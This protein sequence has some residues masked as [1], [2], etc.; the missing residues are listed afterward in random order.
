MQPFDALTIRAVLD[1]AK[2]LLLNRRVDRVF[3]LGR[4]ELLISLR[5]KSGMVH[6]LL[7]AHATY[8]RICLVKQAPQGAKNDRAPQNNSNFALL[9]RKT[10]Q[11]AT[12]VHI[13]QLPGER[14]ADFVFSTTDEVGTASHKVLTAEIM[15][16]HSNLI[17]WDKAKEKIL[18]ASHIVT[19]EMSRHREVA[20]GLTYKRPPGQERPNIFKLTREEFAAQWKLLRENLEQV[21]STTI[22]AV[23]A[24]AESGGTGGGSGGTGMKTQPAVSGPP[25]FATVEQWLLHTYTGLGRN[26]AEELVLASDV[27][28]PVTDAIN[29]SSSED[30]LWSFI[31]LLAEQRLTFKPAMKSDLSRYTVLSLT[32]ELQAESSAEMWKH[33]PAVNDLVDEYYSAVEAREQF[34]QLRERL[35]NELRSED[36]KLNSRISIASQHVKNDEHLNDMKRSGDLVLANLGSIE[37]GQTEL[38]VE[39]LFSG[40]SQKIK[41]KLNPNLSASQNAQWFYRQFSKSRSRQKAAK[42]ALDE[43]AKKQTVVETQMKQLEK[44][45]TN[46]ELRALRELIIGRKPAAVMQQQQINKAGQQADK[47]KSGKPRMLSVTSSDGWT[48]YVGRNR[49]END[50]LLGKLAQ[51]ND[52]WL[53][54]LG[55]GGAHVL[56]RVPASKQEPPLNTLKEAAQIAARL[57]KGGSAGSK[58]RVVYTQVKH[59]KKLG[60]DKPGQVRYENEKTLEVDTSAP[61]PKCMKQLFSH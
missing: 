60:K 42:L 12:L 37:P 6:L 18:T 58:V 53:H 27:K 31:K 55:S 40:D 61:M 56:V 17:F 30:K 48:I 46:E 32:P 22:A 29:D 25:T 13:E 49:H 7:S 39:D 5:S 2:P 4:D 11:S 24:G 14:I 3:Q 1:E 41:I 23:N 16:R 34:N 20:P 38:E 54:I 45:Q 36:E 19:K 51:P 47:K 10:L 57:S 52:I 59:V 33:F 8:G 35:R 21:A 44:A 9:L 15:G 50:Q 26:L 28:S 43:A